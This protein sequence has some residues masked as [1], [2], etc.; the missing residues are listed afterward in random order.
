M[1]VRAVFAVMVLSLLSS[2]AH[3]LEDC[4][5]YGHKCSFMFV[6]IFRSFDQN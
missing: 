3:I 5:L 4:V 6:N 1:P 2:S